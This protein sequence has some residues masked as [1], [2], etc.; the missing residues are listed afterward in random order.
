MENQD[1]NMDHQDDSHI[2]HLPFNNSSQRIIKSKK[3]FFFKNRFLIII[4]LLFGLYHAL[5]VTDFLSFNFFKKEKEVVFEPMHLVNFQFIPA[6]TCFPIS[7]EEFLFMQTHEDWKRVIK[8]LEHYIHSGSIDS[9]TTFHVGV[10]SC[11][12][13]VKREDGKLLH[14]YNPVFK[15]YSENSYTRMIEES[16]ACPGVQKT[17]ERAN[18]VLLQYTDKDG[19]NIIEKF[20]NSTSWAIQS[21]GLYLKG[22]T[23]CEISG[24]A[25][26]GRS[27]LQ[28]FF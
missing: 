21:A 1:N 13:I 27:T 6:E 2:N 14:I 19:D 24:R 3:N 20:T 18:I 7:K 12:M 16:S 25:D 11:F 15:G 5:S 9:I 22:K 28:K 17:I 26:L 8:S 4:I 23:I 10:S